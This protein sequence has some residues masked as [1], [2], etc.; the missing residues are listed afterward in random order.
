MIALMSREMK[1]AVIIPNWNGA[2]LIASCLS[3]LNVQTYPADI[4]VV[5]NG[6]VDESVGIIKARFPSVKIIQ[7]AT[8]TGFT[9]GVNAGVEYVLSQAYD[10]V[11]L[12]NNDAVADKNWLKHLAEVLSSDSQTGIVTCKFLRD[13][14]KRFDSTGECYSIWGTSFP[15]GRNQVDTGQF[16]VPEDVFGASGGASMYR[17][18][19]LKE[20][21][22]LDET[23]F[24]YF[25]DVDISFRARLA[26]WQVRYQ[27]RAVAYHHIGATSS[28]MGSLARYCYIK[29]YYPTYFKNMPGRLVWKYLP[30]VILQTLRFAVGSIVKGYFLT[31]LKA[32]LFALWH[33]PGTFKKRRRVQSKRKV[34]AATIDSLLYHSRPPKIV[35]LD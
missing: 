25:E 32:V 34:S 16:D 35:R 13:D 12:F 29:N 14:K 10:A 11:A 18:D 22:L 17:V 23:Y 24:T 15:R 19:M 3:S 2:D 9:G 33:T 5:D 21:G 27:P 4:V 1:V 26:G 7:L 6:S 30:L 31:F 20:I 8:N 28:K